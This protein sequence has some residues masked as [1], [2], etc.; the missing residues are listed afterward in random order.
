MKEKTC[1][2]LQNPYFSLPLPIISYPFCTFLCMGHLLTAQWN[3]DLKIRVFCEF[4]QKIPEI[5]HEFS[6]ILPLNCVICQ[7]RIRRHLYL[8]LILWLVSC[9]SLYQTFV[10]LR[11][12]S[13]TLPFFWNSGIPGCSS[14]SSGEKLGGK[15]I[16]K[17][18]NPFCTRKKSCRFIYYS[19]IKKQMGTNK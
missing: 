1:K 15:K 13:Q 18:E 4:C 19:I 6:R 7:L 16:R 3:S 11:S 5:Y 9:N 14:K 10:F 8:L 12:L 17:M 2:K